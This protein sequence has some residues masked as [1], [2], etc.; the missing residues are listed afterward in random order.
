[1]NS[2]AC[3]RKAVEPSAGRHQQKFRERDS[4]ILSF[5]F[6]PNGC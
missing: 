3:L 6:I 1:M 5:V 2:F 4:V